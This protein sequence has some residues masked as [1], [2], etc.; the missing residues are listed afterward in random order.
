[1]RRFLLSFC[2]LLLSIQGKGFT[3]EYAELDEAP[4]HYWEAQPQ[5]RFTRLADEL[6]SGRRQLPK[7]DDLTVLRGL[8]E[9]LDIP[10]SSQRLVFS[11]TSLQSGLIHARNPRA[12][13]FNEDTSVGYVPGGRLEILSIDPQLGAIFYIFDL[14]KDSHLPF[15]DRS[16]RCM[17]CH[18]GERMNF[19]PGHA[20]ESAI[21][22]MTGG[23]LEAFRRRQ[24]GHGVPL[25]DRLGGWHV[26]GEGSIKKHHGNVVGKLSPQ[27]LQ[28]TFYKPGELFSWSRYPVETSDMLAHLLHEHQAGFINMVLEGTYRA[29]YALHQSGG[30]LSQGQ[31]QMLDAHAARLVRY[32]LFADEVP[33]PAGGIPG[34]PSYKKAFQSHQ[35]HA[36]PSGAS[37]RDLDLNS[38]LLR[39]RCSYMIHTPMWDAMPEPLLQRV[40]E[41]LKQALDEKHPSA[42]YAYLGTEEKRVIRAILTQSKG[43]QF[44]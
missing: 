22:S 32:V 20:L 18:Q 31:R 44:E 4:H 21:P 34:D 16:T 8:L 40:H 38:R 11:A 27:G 42:E 6:E 37:L 29:R 30:Q 5:D 36:L 25:Q 39:Y 3:Q 43:I 26:T 10:V 2:F 13:Y 35:R 24:F 12:I 41:H 1:M 23:T 14:P 15:I 28:T 7:G 17:N 33:L 9:A 19:I